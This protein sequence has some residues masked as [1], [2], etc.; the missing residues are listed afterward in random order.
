MIADNQNNQ[1]SSLSKYRLKRR[2]I[3]TT[4]DSMETSTAPVVEVPSNVLPVL[5]LFEPHLIVHD[6]WFVD[7]CHSDDGL[8]APV[9]VLSKKLKDVQSNKRFMVGFLI[10]FYNYFILRVYIVVILQ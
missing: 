2:K 7:D 6:I 8:A 9:S 5:N 4:T 10:L 3:D 1:A